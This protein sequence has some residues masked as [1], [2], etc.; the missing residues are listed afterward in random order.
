MGATTI[1][2]RFAPSPTG[3]LHLG[4]A[5]S[6]L[7]AWRRAR[8]AGG[9]FLLRIEDID[10]VR[11]RPEFTDAILEDLAWLGLDWDGE[12]R[13]QSAHL[14][15]YGATLD[16]LSARGLLYPCFCTRADIAREIA[17]SAAA[18]HGPD[19]PL[20]PGTC[21]RLPAD[22]RAARIARGEPHALRLDMAAALATMREPLTFHEER[23][24]RLRCDPAR[25]GDA[26]LARKDVP[27]SYHLCVTHDDALQGV[28]LVTRGED[29]KPATD[30]HRLLQHLMGWPEPTYAHHGLLTD[31]TGKRLAKRD[32]AATIREMRAAGATAAEVRGRAGE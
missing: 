32:R 13:V 28:T 18:P 19:G 6:A 23:E 22:E 16:A 27:A 17:A 30:L 4:H 21:R 12:V 26:V 3:H 24:G 2:T 15:E 10:P 1:V 11:C 8:E 14:P 7:F 25:F 5:H 20:Y 29:L 31:E 9:R